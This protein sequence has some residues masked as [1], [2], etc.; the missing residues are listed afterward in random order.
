MSNKARD[1]AKNTAILTIG[2]I[3]SQAITF[4]LLP[5]YTAYLSRE[6]YGIV[7]LVATIV[8]L[9][10]PILNLQMEQALFRY[11]VVSR[12]DKG[13]LTKIASTAFSFTGFQILCFSLL[14]VA[15][16]PFIHN[17]YKWFLL[18][19]LILG[20][21][22]FMMMQFLRG[23]GDNVGYAVSAFLASVVNIAVNLVLILGFGLGA[24]SM[25]TAMAVGSIISIIY[26]LFRSKLWKYYSAKSFELTRLKELLRYSLPLVPNEL[27]WWAIRASD[28]VIITSFLGAGAN[29]IIAIAH[30][31]PSIY[32]MLYNIFGIAWTESVVLHLKEPDG[33]RYFS[34]MTNRM[35][36][37]FSCMALLIVVVL[38]FVFDLLIDDSFGEAY[39]LIPL[40]LIGS[41]FNVVIG[42]V[43]AV[44]IVH[45]QTMVIAK[46][47]IMAA[48]IC[49]AVDVAFVKLIGIYAS[50]LSN[51]IGF[52]AMMLYRCIDVKRYVK[53]K[54]NYRYIALFCIMLALAI[55]AYY[56]RINSICAVMVVL[57]FAF[58]YYTNKGDLSK[59]RDA[60][61]ARFN[62]IRA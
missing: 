33:E 60:V 27:A 25:L 41:I 46:T 58:V 1:L 34:D 37:L 8:A 36:R 35:I 56:I 31:F 57:A 17:E 54:W 21:L 2:K 5:L 23:L 47:S 61:K 18:I 26:I 59:L 4:F 6:D 10:F 42:L 40:Y 32:V 51:I 55:G 11:M 48:I 50:P 53:V 24:D 16:S 15:A 49:L 29:G 20:T 43:S 12:E 52:G 39:N 38:P 9:L 22:N 62:T 7:D 28:R 14:F 13:E 45:K 3:C 19:N 30:K 44:Y